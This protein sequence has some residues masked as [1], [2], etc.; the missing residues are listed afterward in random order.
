MDRACQERE[1]E[2]AS[3]RR[4]DAVRSN[5]KKEVKSERA[6]KRVE[7]IPSHF[8]SLRE[9]I[10][11]RMIGFAEIAELRLEGEGVEGNVDL[12]CTMNR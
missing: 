11:G 10:P 2:G 4:R 9:G 7:I 12:E 6:Q 5:E 1:A 8:A 3:H